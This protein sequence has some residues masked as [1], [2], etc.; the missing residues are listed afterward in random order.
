MVGS[1]NENRIIPDV[2][3]PVPHEGRS[4]KKGPA[5]KRRARSWIEQ[6]RDYRQVLLPPLPLQLL[7]QHSELDE[8]EAPGSRQVGVW[9]DGSDEHDGSEQSAPLAQSS[10]E[11]LLQISNVCVEQSTAQLPQFSSP[12]QA[13]S[14]Q[15]YVVGTVGLSVHWK[16]AAVH[17]EFEHGTGFEPS[18][19]PQQYRL[20]GLP[21]CLPA[22]SDGQLTQS[23]PLPASH[24]PLPHWA[25][26]ED[27]ETQSLGQLLQSSPRSHTPSLS[28]VTHP[29]HP[30]VS[31]PPQSPS[32]AS[33]PPEHPRST[34]VW[35]PR[36][37]RSHTSPGSVVSLPHTAGV[38]AV[39]PAA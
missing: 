1:S 17:T 11:P 28:H 27:P 35:P 10:S 20:E 3:S 13:L 4:K 7:E 26:V 29:V 36:S 31:N 25:P 16:P 23:S 15:Q 22:Q 12:P 24:T 30:D 8:H 6:I 34:Q 21:L 14:P 9:H 39:R 37:V 18:P 19:S 32:H 2:R 5:P 38:P 33:V